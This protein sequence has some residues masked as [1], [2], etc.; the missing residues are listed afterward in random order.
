MTENEDRLNPDNKKFSY[1]FYN[2]VT[3]IGVMISLVVAVV[4]V[5]L[6]ALDFFDK[7]HNLYLGLI[8]YLILP[9]FLILGLLLIPA[10][11]F[12]KKSRIRRGLPLIELRR[13]RIDLSLSHHRNTL[14]VFIISTAILMLMSL[15]GSYKAFHYTESVKFC[16]VLCHEV[17]HPEFTAYTN[18]PHG[19]V[20]CVECHIG[21]GAGWYVQSKLSGARQVVKAIANSYERPIHTPVANLRPAEDTCKQCHWPGKYF[22]T[23]DL[24]RTHY[25]SDEK[26]SPWKIR[27]LLNVGAGQG[28]SA[29]VHAHMNLDQDIY[30]AAED[31]RRQK[32]SWVKTVA[33]DGKETLYVTPKSK[34]KDSAPPPEAVRKMDCIDCHNRPTHQ[35]QAPYQFLNKAMQTGAIDPSL[36]K[37]KEKAMEL[38]S[39]KYANTPEAVAAIEKGIRDLYQTD[40]PD[41]Y[42]SESAKIERA[43]DEVVK[44]YENNLF[45]EMKT[46]WDTHPD[47]IG[48]LAAPGCFRCHDDQHV[49]S[50]GKAVSKD[51]RSCHVIV[52][53]GAPDAL[54]K[55]LE[56][57][58]FKHPDGGEEWKEM[59]CV[60]CHTGGA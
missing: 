39:K 41:V 42:A 51:C 46:R 58:E 19:R 7:G 34:W 16:G 38:V 25:L 44:L 50:A 28:Q 8:T 36:P 45:P 32:I 9:G 54:E 5:F 26:N 55:N 24:N 22:G 3:Y 31:E 11:V 12:W 49:S 17:M 59:D 33:R 37:I 4:E 29:G 18:S 53:Q 20:K 40:Y 56:G 21:E 52:E 27:M 57:L 60:D 6:F 48:H 15:V 14:L 23:L 2:A 13:F 43:I 10:G 35:F 47:N 30:Y 1:L